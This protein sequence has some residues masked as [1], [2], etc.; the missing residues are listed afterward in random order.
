M[1]PLSSSG[2]T[3]PR[4]EKAILPFGSML[5]RDLIMC[6]NSSSAPGKI[7]RKTLNFSIQPH[8]TGAGGVATWRMVA[9]DAGSRCSPGRG[10][11][12]R[13]PPRNNYQRPCH[14]VNR[15]TWINDRDKIVNPL[16]LREETVGGVFGFRDDE[17]RPGILWISWGEGVLRGVP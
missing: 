4:I 2:L 14:V 12:R 17:E 15:K 10:S 5:R 3:L 11:G 1:A 13:K 7:R 8:D 9:I 16:K 6:S